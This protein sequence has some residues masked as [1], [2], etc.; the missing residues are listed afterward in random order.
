MA[1]SVSTLVVDDSR[2]MRS[3]IRRVLQESDL[4]DRVEVVG[5]AGSGVEAVEKFRSLRPDLVIMD[6][7]MPLGSGVDV[8]R[9][10]RKIDRD[11]KVIMVTAL[12][13]EEM[14]RETAD[15]GISGFVPKPFKPED[16]LSAVR[17]AVEALPSRMEA[18]RKGEA[19]PPLTPRPARQRRPLSKKKIEALGS[20]LGRLPERVRSSLLGLGWEG[21]TVSIV[22]WDLSGLDA[23]EVAL[24]GARIVLYS[25]VCRMKGS[26]DPVLVSAMP[27]SS[28]RILSKISDAA[29]E[30][31]QDAFWQ[32]IKEVHNI[33]QTCITLTLT[34]DI[35]LKLQP[36]ST[37]FSVDTLSNL[38]DFV[39]ST[40]SPEAK[41]ALFMNFRM[42]VKGQATNMLILLFLSK[43]GL[44]GLS[45]RLK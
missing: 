36:E 27:G 37:L 9:D 13:Q 8:L 10:I 17:L 31:G 35:G 20:H 21:A 6:I 4:S 14:R 18:E 15:L 1:G 30:V 32:T 7:V 16:I 41:Y 12:D 3:L 40:I 23:L 2:F 5:E 11:A 33:L 26:G 24:G 38:T 29:A 25:T 45:R 22:S 34:E 44:T 42:A 43:S 39:K 19:A 28:T